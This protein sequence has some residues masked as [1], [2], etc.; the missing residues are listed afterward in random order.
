MEITVQLE[1]LK[2]FDIGF[3]EFPDAI[4]TSLTPF[5][6]D[7]IHEINF[8]SI[9][10]PSFGRSFLASFKVNLDN[11]LFKNT[12]NIKVIPVAHK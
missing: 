8:C 1:C 3:V 7:S 10:K 11:N 12:K 5:S 4:I 2:A 6:N 9:P